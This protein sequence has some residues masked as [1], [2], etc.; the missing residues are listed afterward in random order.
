MTVS[1]FCNEI[2]H[3]QNTYLLR[4][5]IIGLLSVPLSQQCNISIV[6]S[7]DVGSSEP[8]ILTLGKLE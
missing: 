2:V 7:N 3:S 6:F 8:L 1:L 5:D 4:N